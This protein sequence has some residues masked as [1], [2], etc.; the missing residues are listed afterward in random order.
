MIEPI[1]DTVSDF[2]Q[3]IVNGDFMTAVT[4]IGTAL[5]SGP[6][7]IKGTVMGQD[8]KG[9]HS[10]AMKD[11][12]QDMKDLIVK[13]MTDAL[14]KEREGSLT[15]DVF[16]GNAGI[17]TINSSAVPVAHHHQETFHILM[18]VDVAEQ[19]KQKEAGR[20]ITRRAV[21]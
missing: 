6:C 8:V 13:P 2:F 9:D 18:A 7:G 20:V 15:G 5:V 3:H 11:I 1:K 4:K 21:R 14:S 19:V 17:G 12:D 10:Q 16:H